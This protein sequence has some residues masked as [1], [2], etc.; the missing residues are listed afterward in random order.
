MMNLLFVAL[1]LQDRE[2]TRDRFPLRPLE[3]RR[4]E[5]EIPS[6]ERDD[7]MKPPLPARYEDF[8]SNRLFRGRGLYDLIGGGT[9]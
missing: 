4:V 3:K 7:P 6:F 9:S 8:P 2:L 5:L 1:A